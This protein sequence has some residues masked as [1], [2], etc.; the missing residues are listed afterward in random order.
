MAENKDE[1]RGRIEAAAFEVLEEMGYRK[2]SMLQIAKRA[3][4]SNETLY[5]WYGNKQALFSSIIEGNASGIRQVLEEAIA[6]GSDPEHSLENVGRLLLRFTA[7]DNAVIINRA[8]VADVADT[9]LLAAAIETHARSV[10]MQRLA[11]F[12]ERVE[13]A[14]PFDF[15]GD[16]GGAADVF[17]RLLLGELQIQQALGSQPPLDDD[18]IERRSEECAALFR[19]LY[20]NGAGSGR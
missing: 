13:A 18:A 1:R 4:A 8:A 6:G 14:G 20:A 5:N 7:T 12:M 2:A 17:I 15:K 11:A 9:G 3:Q 16:P 10:M 19:R